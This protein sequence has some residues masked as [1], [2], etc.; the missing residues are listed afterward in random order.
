MGTFA[1]QLTRDDIEPLAAYFS[2]QPG[3]STP[4]R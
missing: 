2:S 1:G 4:K 3:L